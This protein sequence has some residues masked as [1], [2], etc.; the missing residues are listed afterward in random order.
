MAA[1][2]YLITTVRPVRLLIH[3]SASK[4]SWAVWSLLSDGLASRAYFMLIL[5]YACG[6]R[7]DHRPAMGQNNPIKTT[8][9]QNDPVGQN[10]PVPK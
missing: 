5:P 1:P 9:S 3:G 2:P 6:A 7:S 4:S 10:N 8:P